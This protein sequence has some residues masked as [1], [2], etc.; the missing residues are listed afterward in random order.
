MR[1]PVIL[2]TSLWTHDVRSPWR[3]QKSNHDL[4][5]YLNNPGLVTESSRSRCNLLR[6]GIS[7][8]SFI[9]S[10]VL[11][12][13]YKGTLHVW[14]GREKGSRQHTEGMQHCQ[15]VPGV[16]VSKGYIAPPW[17]SIS[18]TPLKRTGGTSRNTQGKKKERKK[19]KVILVVRLDEHLMPPEWGCSEVQVAPW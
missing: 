4:V 12:G 7:R 18:Y 9:Q 2:I 14:T 13:V 6:D 19:K 15:I 8:I 11:T 5:S 3:R 17:G 10:C 1:A 16:R